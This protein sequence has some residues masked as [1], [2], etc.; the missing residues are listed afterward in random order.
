[1]SLDL[2]EGEA[3]LASILDILDYLFDHYSDLLNLDI[4]MFVEQIEDISC[5]VDKRPCADTYLKF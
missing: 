1:M 4:K 5:G 2:F 3:L